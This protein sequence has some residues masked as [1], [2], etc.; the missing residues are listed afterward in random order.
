M[1]QVLGDRLQEVSALVPARRR[2]LLDVQVAGRRVAGLAHDADPLPGANPLSLAEMG[3][4]LQVRIHPVVP[5]LLAVDHQVVA[6]AACL[7]GPPLH[8]ATAGRHQRGAASSQDV[9]SLVDVARPRGANPVAVAVT[10]ANRELEAVVG[11]PGLCG[12]FHTAALGADA[13]FV[14]AVGSRLATP[15]SAPSG[16]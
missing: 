5:G 16:G 12:R 3:P 11:E 9:L 7:V 4:P 2:P 1:P 15:D 10:A 6:G 8:A 14:V 13:E